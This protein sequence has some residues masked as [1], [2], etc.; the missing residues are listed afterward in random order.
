MNQRLFKLKNLFQEAVAPAEFKC[1]NCGADV[2][3]ELGFCPKCLQEVTFNNGKTCKRCGVAIH[4]EED[5]CG[6]CAFEKTY[7]DRAYSPFCYTGAVQHAILQMKFQRMATNA[8][9]LARYLV[10]CAQKYE[11]QFDTV[12]YVP[13]TAKAKR[14][15]GYN[16]AQLLAMHFCDILNVSAPIA[17]LSKV[18]ETELQENLNRQGRKENIAG[19]FVST[20]EAKGKRVLVIDDI[21]T[22]G[23]TLNE[24][25]KAL[26]K[27]GATSVECLTVASREEDFV[28]ELQWDKGE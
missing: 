18:K 20:G 25:A 5:Y 7:F 8:K 3:D 26:K 12:T 14:K 19:A 6:H 23:A 28:A 16:Q 10:F 17:L 13:M 4:G 27:K 9:V 1:L 21:K 22:S 15:R 24:C 2:F 11:L